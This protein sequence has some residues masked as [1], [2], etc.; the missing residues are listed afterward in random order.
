MFSLGSLLICG[1]K[2]ISVCVWGSK[3]NLFAIRC[4]L[5]PKIQIIVGDVIKETDSTSL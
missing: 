3:K 1:Q 2:L 4:C 5:F